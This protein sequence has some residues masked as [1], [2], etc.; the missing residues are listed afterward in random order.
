[1]AILTHNLLLFYFKK[2]MPYKK[3]SMEMIKEMRALRIE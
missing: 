1:V 2:L 3:Y